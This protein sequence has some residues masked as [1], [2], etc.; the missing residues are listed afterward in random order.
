MA[1]PNRR[2]P[3]TSGPK[4]QW[5]PNWG[6]K[7]STVVPGSLYRPVSN[8]SSEQQAIFDSVVDGDGSILVEARAG[9]GKT[10]VCVETMYRLLRKY[11]KASIAYLIFAKRNAEEALGKCPPGTS[12]KTTHAFGLNALSQVYGKIL[13]DKEKTDRIATAL[14]GPDPEKSELRY[15]LGKGMDLGKDYNASTPEEIVAIVDKHG[16]ETGDMTESEFADKV[17]KGMEESARQPNIVSFSDMVWLPLK[18]GIKIPTFDYV[19]ADE[20][21][22]LNPSRIEL[23]LRTLGSKGRLIAVF[24]EAQAIFGFSG[25]DKNAVQKLCNGTNGRTL[26]LHKTYRCAKAIVALA[27]QYVPDYEA[28]ETNPDGEVREATEQE[29]LSENGARA[30]DFILSR[31][32]APCAKIAM[33]LLKEGRKCNI[34]GKDLGDS[35]LF[36]IKRSKAKS[37]VEFQSWL[38]DWKNAEI[39]RLN[40]KKRDYEHIVDKAETLESFCEGQRNIE[41]VKERISSMFSDA[42]SNEEH[43]ITISS[44]HKS[45]GLER[46][47]VWLLESSFVV[48][49][50]TE[51]DIQQEKNVRY[52]AITRAKNQLNL[53]G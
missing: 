18:L 9:C 50:K 28:A 12:S 8:P 53:V 4:K 14:V 37:V 35:L 41:D 42:E 16:L 17:L 20:S 38:E 34:Q 10:T 29:M 32:N 7:K 46:D 47:R 39:E 5:N 25:A 49:P 48:R 26:P 30:G 2:Y 19:F 43:R 45:K 51:E 15:M 40:A 52:V 31:T 21:Q 24:D 22:D 27:K 33:R 36:M 13:V 11:S 23:T 3:Q 44:I 6:K 1:Y